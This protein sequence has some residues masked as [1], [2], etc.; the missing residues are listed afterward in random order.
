MNFPTES[1]LSNGDNGH[2]VEKPMWNMN[3]AER[4]SHLEQSRLSVQP[5]RMKREPLSLEDNKR[6]DAVFRQHPR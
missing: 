4:R 3:Q 5:L 6:L 2:P 1:H